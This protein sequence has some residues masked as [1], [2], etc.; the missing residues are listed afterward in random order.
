M[1]FSKDLSTNFNEF[2]ETSETSLGN[3]SFKVRFYRK[4]LLGAYYASFYMRFAAVDGEWK[5]ISL[6]LSNY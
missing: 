1:L 2:P 4:K 6:D 3:M 5:V